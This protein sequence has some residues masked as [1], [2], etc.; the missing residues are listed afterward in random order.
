MSSTY[1][2]IK[3]EENLRKHGVSFDEV[4]VFEWDGAVTKQDTRF[5][6]G[7]SR[8]ISTGYVNGRLHVLVW[9]LR[10]NAIRPISFRKA[11]LRERV[12][13]EKDKS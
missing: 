9:T 8:F 12:R 2:T 10:N 4:A 1:D 13:Y 3:N 11:N 7:E 6:Y 5:E